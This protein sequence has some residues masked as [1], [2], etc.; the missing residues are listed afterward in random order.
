MNIL[1]LGRKDS[2]L[3]GFLKE[4]ENITVT[5]EKINRSFIID[6]K[7]DFIISYG[8]RH[9]I[10]KEVLNLVD[11]INLHISY[12]PYNKG[13]DPVFWSIID[14]TP[15]GVTIHRVDETYDT[16]DILLQELVKITEED[17][18]RTFYKKLQEKIE[19]LFVDNWELLKDMIFKIQINKAHKSVD[20]E[21][22]IAGIKSRYL[23]MKIPNLI[24]YVGDVQMSAQ[25]SEEYIQEI[26]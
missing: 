13:A 1:F 19:K 24:N 8:Y 14:D 3:I 22:Y 10:K 21:K 26:K 5:D 12:L 9:L 4:S 11:A 2:P 25:F 20:K 23:D 15:K 6:N 7:I 18:L 17:T 16:G